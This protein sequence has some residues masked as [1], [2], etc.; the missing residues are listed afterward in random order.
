MST[1]DPLTLQ[2]LVDG[3]LSHA[4]RAE[5]L[6]GLGEDAHG[7]RSLAMALLEEQQWSRQIA[8]ASAH[9]HRASSAMQDAI[10]RASVSA[11]AP[12]ASDADARVA[13]A[14]HVLPTAPEKANLAQGHR[15]T[16]HWMSVL[17]ASALFAVGLWGGASLRSWQRTGDGNA[18]SGTQV[19]TSSRVGNG[20][21][22]TVSDNNTRLVSDNML[23]LPSRDSV[24]HDIPLVDSREMDPELIMTKEAYELARLKHDFKRRGYQIDVQP[25]WH[26]GSLGDGRTVVVPIQ[27]VSLRPNGL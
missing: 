14:S 19:A 13:V 9:P 25:E 15:S 23:R 5:L 1:M 10:E 6:R 2:R 21:L 7:W 26:T 12:V 3:E 20:S 16:W 8:A 27:N 18:T 22:G 11:V 24:S 4:E 17:A